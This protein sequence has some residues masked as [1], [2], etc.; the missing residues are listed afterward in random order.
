M[1]P[2]SE[3]ASLVVDGAVVQDGARDAEYTR[4]LAASVLASYKREA[5]ALPSSDRV[6]R[7][8]P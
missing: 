4:S 6:T 3:S 1:M 7:T 8:S 2:A 5:V